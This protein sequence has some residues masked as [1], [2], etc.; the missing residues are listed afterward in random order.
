MKTEYI[1]KLLD[2]YYNGES[3]KDDEN[4]LMKYFRSDEVAPELEDERTVFLQLSDSV[5]EVPFNPMLGSKLDAL[6]T[7]LA[8]QEEKT[9][10]SNR[11][12]TTNKKKYVL[13]WAVSAAACIAILFSIGF[14]IINKNDVQQPNVV[15]QTELKDTFSDPDEAYAEA[16]KALLLVSKNLNKGLDQLA[17]AQE[18]IHKSTEIVNK[19][20]NQITTN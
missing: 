5:D 19:S 10:I 8:T 2:A 14:F 20:L 18:N 9:A 3:T 17:L 4:I 13:F 11:V 12:P 15:A 1:Q 6:I 16:E 7:D